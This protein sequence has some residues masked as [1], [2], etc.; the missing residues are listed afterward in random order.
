LPGRR[1]RLSLRS[2]GKIDVAAI[3]GKLGGGGHQAASGC[4]MEGPIPRALDEILAVLRAAVPAVAGGT[5]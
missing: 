2:K 3:A 1:I 4:T 5:P